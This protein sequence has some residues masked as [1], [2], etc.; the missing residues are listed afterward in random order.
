MR[1]ELEALDTIAALIY[2]QASLKEQDN[3]LKEA[4]ELG[5][6]GPFGED[7]RWQEDAEGNIPADELP[8]VEDIDPNAGRGK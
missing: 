2:Y 1:T 7:G 6:V 3:W 4:I 8:D 5:F